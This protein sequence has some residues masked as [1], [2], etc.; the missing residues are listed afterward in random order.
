MSSVGYM[1]IRQVLLHN[2]TILKAQWLE[3][4]KGYFF[5]MRSPLSVQVASQSVGSGVHASLILW[6]V[7]PYCDVLR[8]A[9]AELEWTVKHQQSTSPLRINHVT[10]DYVSSTKASH[11]AT[12]NFKGCEPPKTAE[13]G[14]HFFLVAG[15]GK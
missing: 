10:S 2:W 4:T 5:L 9:E 7:P 13:K 8:A 12:I 1:R 14:K 11:V 6:L 3:T 15:W